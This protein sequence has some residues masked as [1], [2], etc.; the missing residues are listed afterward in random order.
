MN[1]YPHWIHGHP[2]ARQTAAIA[3]PLTLRDVGEGIFVGGVGAELCPEVAEAPVVQLYESLPRLGRRFDPAT[4]LAIGERALR[5]PFF[6]GDP[7][8]AAVL[9][10]VVAWC[11][12][13][14]VVLVQ[15]QA[16]YSRSASVGYALLRARGVSH[17]EALR[18]VVVR[19]E[20]HD[21]DEVWPRRVTLE[22]CV[23]WANARYGR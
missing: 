12:G 15:C 18:R 21:R 7:V 13:E 17:A 1:P 14:P 11:A 6:D 19:V 2:A 23:V 22:S 8:D 4:G 10:E 9:D 5:R 3:L 16:G 20:R